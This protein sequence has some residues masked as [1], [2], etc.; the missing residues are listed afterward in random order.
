MSTQ[1]DAGTPDEPLA[2]RM[3]FEDPH[4]FLD[5]YD[6]QLSRCLV[7]LRHP[8][9]VPIGS[10]MLVIISPPDAL[11]RL[12]LEG[13]VGRVTPRPNGTVRL[14]VEVSFDVESMQWLDAYVAGL[15]AGLS[16]S[17]SGPLAP[18]SSTEFDIRSELVGLAERLDELTY[19]EVLSLSPTSDGE[20]IRRRYMTLA[21]LYHPETMSAE[22]ERLQRAAR[23]VQRRLNEAYGVL[24][25]PSLRSAYDAGLDGPAHARKLRVDE[26]GRDALRRQAGPRGG[27]T[28]VGDAYWRLARN[29]LEGA[30]SAGTGP[31]MSAAIGESIRLLR[32]A[33]AFEPGNPHFRN[34]L[35]Q[36]LDRQR[37]LEASGASRGR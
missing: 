9:A 36:V 31:A 7:G 10:R 24:R 20:Q 34:A 11:D 35:D 8:E 14:R 3:R 29:V 37:A 6:R 23:R 18:D 26:Q 21:R 16:R 17:R 30:R 2:S 5:F 28:P 19:Y 15:R 32:T 33:L 1:P 22:D 13:R 27:A 12:R 25:Q 4:K